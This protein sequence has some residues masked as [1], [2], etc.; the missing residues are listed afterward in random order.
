M[1]NSPERGRPVPQA[2]AESRLA[3]LG[4]L[5]AAHPDAVVAAFA[6]DGVRIAIPDSFPLGEH[7]AL[8]VPAERTTMLDVVLPADRLA[9][10]AAWERARR[11]AIA[12]TS[13][14]ALAH[15]D[16]RFTLSMLDVRERYG[17][18][19]AVLTPDG[20][21][22]ES[23]PDGLAGPLVVTARP[24]QA[25]MHKNMT[26]TITEVDAN[27][28]RMLGWTP[29]QMLGRRSSDL[30]HPDDQERAVSVWMQL[31][32]SMNP[33]RV[34]VRNRCSDGSWLWVE[35]EHIH[36]GAADPDDV[37]V[38]SYISDI[39]DEM[40][41]HEAVRYRE[42]LFGSLAE[43]LPIGV[44]QLRLDGSIVYA[45]A[46]L[47]E[48]LQIAT[49]VAVADLFAA[50][51]ARDRPD[52]QVAVAA[53]LEQGTKADL[54]IDVRSR[55]ASS[56]RRCALTVTA[57][58][59]QHGEPAAL[60]CVNDITE[61]ARM[62]DE[63]RLQATHDALTGLPNHRALI[64]AID[65]ELERSKR[66][67]SGFAL[68]FLD[69]DHFKALN[70][71]L[72]HGPGDTALHEA[73]Q[74]IAS[75]L[76]AVDTV[77]RWGGEEFVVLLPDTDSDAALQVTE[78]IRAA[79]ASHR[80]TSCDGPRLTCSIGV[81]TH[82]DDGTDRD[83]LLVSADQAMYAA[84]QLGRNQ[85]IKARDQ[86]AAALAADRTTPE[87]PD[88][89]ALLGAVEALAALV[90]ARDGY[91]A[92]HSAN[93]ALLAQRLAV[94]L[95][96]DPGEAHAIHLAARLHDIGKVAIPDAILHKPGRLTNDE[97]RL[98]RQHPAIGADVAGLIP[99]LRPITPMIRGHHE[100]YDGTGYPDG[101][102]GQAIPLGARIISA[103][104]AYSAITTDRPYG[105]GR[106]HEDALQELQRCAG[107]QF[108]ANIVKA[109]AELLAADHRQQHAA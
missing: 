107:T 109:L 70:D 97:W 78:R 52:V 36:N 88:E 86:I 5:L 43:A 104:D 46:H 64:A 90:D 45:N 92:A 51:D 55:R 75:C 24:R 81:A 76:R 89:Q 50:I 12:V 68:A 53:A 28:S 30:I 79:I 13:V 96:C 66:S 49:P 38:T 41:A 2:D 94:S 67:G 47:S 27:A 83:T 103:A 93:V 7:Q 35:V 37:D 74:L 17:V 44:L 11:H 100:R 26:A 72:G 25:T 108:D 62:R 48:I 31:L 69:L 60:V 19:L 34:R 98:I 59:D 23:S 84:K 106:S 1:G 4:S 87:A 8:A 56:T 91:T 3:A 42:Q 6:E 85:V 63:L 14:H 54:E 9:V 65:Q 39:S 58:A 33:Q 61:S 10:V 16:T 102:A 21:E 101:L 105:D 99:P 20:D 82:P 57:V 22:A 73:G 77:G 29:E 15:P 18:W 95:G 32:S 40:A 80:Y 71:T